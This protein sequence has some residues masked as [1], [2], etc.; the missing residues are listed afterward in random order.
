MATDLH[1]P[2][3][4]SPCLLD[5]SIGLG[6]DNGTLLGFICT[7]MIKVRLKYPLGSN[8]WC[9]NINTATSCAN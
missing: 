5:G 7:A 8:I 3:L 1:Y 9:N 2:V 4:T 6:C